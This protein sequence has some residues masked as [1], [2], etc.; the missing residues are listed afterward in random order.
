MQA[1][2]PLLASE[3]QLVPVG[4]SVGLGVRLVVSPAAGRLRHLPPARFEAGKEW[5]SRGQ[6][7]ALVENG[8]VSIEVR[9][10]IEGRLAGVL[11]RDGEPVAAGQPL[12]WLDDS[13]IRPA[14]ESRMGKP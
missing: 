4:E 9:S 7:V 14:A 2:S 6:A 13:P 1:S 8:S 10:P 12:V 3:A 11:V 5:V